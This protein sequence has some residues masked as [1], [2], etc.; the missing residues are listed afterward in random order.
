MAKQ[1]VEQILIRRH[2]LTVRFVRTVLIV[3]LAFLWT[4]ASNHCKLEQ[5]PGLEFLSCCTHD[6]TAP[7]QDDDCQDDGCA[8]FEN[9]LYKTE[10]A[11]NSLPSPAL[12]FAAF[13]NP[14]WAELSA[15]RAI[16]PVLPD[17]APTG[18]SRVWQFSYRTALPPRAPSP[19]S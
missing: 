5:I 7:H 10:N 13:L 15:P 9:Q 11:R 19:A 16:N 3:A 6:E 2:L 8:T 17:A 4:A 12:L 1:L 18:L 14:G